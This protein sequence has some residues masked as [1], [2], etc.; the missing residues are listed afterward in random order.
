MVAGDVTVAQST[1]AL[2]D[3]FEYLWMHNVC[4]HDVP[5]QLLRHVCNMHPHDD[6][7]HYNCT[8]DVSDLDL[9]RILAAAVVCIS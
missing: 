5:F 2:Q 4:L 6:S 3:V 8:C 7:W 9:G 1:V